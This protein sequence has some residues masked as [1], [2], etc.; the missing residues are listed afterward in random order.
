MLS[1][2]YKLEIVELQATR[3]SY[4]RTLK[5]LTIVLLWQ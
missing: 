3:N 5:Q 1:L 4:I 2:E